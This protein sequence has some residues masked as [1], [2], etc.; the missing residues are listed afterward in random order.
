MRE[1]RRDVSPVDRER[2]RYRHRDRDGERD[3]GRRDAFS[4]GSGRY[5]ESSR[6]ESGRHY[7]REH[8]REPSHSRQHRVDEFGRNID[9]EQ[10]D[11]RGAKFNRRSH[12]S[13]SRSRDRVRHHSRSRDAINDKTE[14]SR[15]RFKDDLSDGEDAVNQRDSVVEKEGETV[16]LTEEELMASMMGFGGFD[17]TK[18]GLMQIYF[19]LLYYLSLRFPSLKLS[20]KIDLLIQEKTVAGNNIGAIDVKKKR[21]YKQVCE[22]F[23]A[24]VLS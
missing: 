2:D 19:K 11:Y 20:H 13:R 24:C 16:P 8:E 21:G 12:R 5:E 17:S 23:L 3:R 6:Y 15:K 22:H 7:E 9:S 14:S 18:V 4:R 10:H 1:G